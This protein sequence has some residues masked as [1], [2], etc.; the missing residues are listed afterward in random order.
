MFCVVCNAFSQ[1][2]L[3][4]LSVHEDSYHTE[5]CNI[6]VFSEN[7][8]VHTKH[9]IVQ[10]PYIL[11]RALVWASLSNEFVPHRKQQVPLPP[12]EWYLLHRE[13]TPPVFP[14]VTSSNCITSDMP[15][16]SSKSTSWHFSEQCIP[17]TQTA[18][19]LWIF[20][21]R[22][23]CDAQKTVFS[24]YSR[25]YASLGLPKEMGSCHKEKHGVF[26]YCKKSACWVTWAWITTTQ[27]P[28]ST[29]IGYQLTS[30]YCTENR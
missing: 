13:Q 30:L 15:P 7:G 3:L 22:R 9:K 20:S 19:S 10:F 28:P 23:V 24:A 2:P 18:H 26:P 17:T 4:G 25:K 6:I 29:Y 14:C 8:K 21:H 27:K 5:K 16:Q 1:Q 12:T 11:G